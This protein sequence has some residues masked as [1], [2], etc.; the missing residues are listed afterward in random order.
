METPGV[1]FQLFYEEIQ[2]LRT[3]M[4]E[5]HRSETDTMKAGFTELGNRFSMHEEDDQKVA[6]KVII[7]E[8]RQRAEKELKVE[9]LDKANRRSTLISSTVAIAVTVGFKALEYFRVIGH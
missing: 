7:I 5:M 8:E 9:A 1:P 3:A 6:E 4:L 2:N